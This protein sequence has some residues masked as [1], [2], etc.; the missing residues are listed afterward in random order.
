MIKKEH[1]QLY[2]EF[3]PAGI[4]RL[5]TYYISNEDVKNW[6]NGK[7]NP[8]KLWKCQD[9]NKSIEKFIFV[10]N[11]KRQHLLEHVD[12]IKISRYTINTQS[13]QDY[14]VVN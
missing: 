6:I 8:K 4:A 2:K 7:T 3:G 14:S 13:Q 9:I 12:S 5:C 11:M 10:R 1:L